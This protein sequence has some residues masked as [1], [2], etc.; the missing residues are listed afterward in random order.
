MISLDISS[1]ELR[2]SWR[3]DWIL[4][5]PT[6]TSQ[7]AVRR[8]DLAGAW[9]LDLEDYVWSLALSPLSSGQLCFPDAERCTAF[10]RHALPT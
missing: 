1:V 2:D 4:R 6:L 5:S 9:G 8:G 10:P 3:D 7:R